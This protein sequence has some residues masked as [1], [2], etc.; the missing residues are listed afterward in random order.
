MAH[1]FRSAFFDLSLN[2]RC[3]RGVIDNDA[4]LV[5]VDEEAACHSFSIGVEGDSLDGQVTDVSADDHTNE[6]EQAARNG[7]RVLGAVLHTRESKHGPE[8]R[9][10]SKTPRK[11][12][13]TFP[14]HQS[15]LACRSQRR[16][17]GVSVVG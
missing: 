7:S 14:A 13:C 11:N 6:T 16:S 2:L 1:C 4:E 12:G 15:R 9:K 10:G 17:A 3:G 5:V 8:A